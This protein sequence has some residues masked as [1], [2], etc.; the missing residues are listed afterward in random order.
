[1]RKGVV[2]LFALLSVGLASTAMAA[3]TMP[4]HVARP[5]GLIWGGGGNAPPT[6]VQTSSEGRPISTSFR[7]PT[8]EQSPVNRRDWSR[9]FSWIPQD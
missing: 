1:M 5:L 9:W 3:G 6:R 7:F 2:V 8:T 4:V